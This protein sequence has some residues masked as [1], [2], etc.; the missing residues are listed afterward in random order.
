M[1]KYFNRY[2]IKLEKIY[3]RKGKNIISE[4]M[5][6][7][8]KK[9][10]VHLCIQI[11]HSDFKLIKKNMNRFTHFN[12]QDAGHKPGKNYLI[13]KIHK[14]GYF[15]GITFRQPI[16]DSNNFIFAKCLSVQNN[17]DYVD[18]KEKIFKHSLSNIKNINALK[19]AIKRRYKKS[20]AHLSDKEKL[21]LGVA[22]TELKI[23]KRF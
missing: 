17:I 23:I 3:F 6:V 12:I 21:S 2:P 10:N 4:N 9:Y 15:D 14:R 18:L 13:M 19:K 7:F 5:G 11:L 1:K 16:Y 22:I 8:L 20:L